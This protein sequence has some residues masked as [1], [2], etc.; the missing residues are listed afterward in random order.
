MGKRPARKILDG[1]LSRQ[2]PQ[3]K[4]RGRKFSFSAL[5]FLLPL[6]LVFTFAAVVIYFR[7]PTFT[8]SSSR[9]ESSATVPK[10]KNPW[11]V[12]VR[13]TDDRPLSDEQMAE[14]AAIV[15]DTV[16]QGKKS[17][18][19]DASRL[20]VQK[21]A[22]GVAAVTRTGKFGLVVSVSQRVPLLGVYADKPRFLTEDG[23][24]YGDYTAESDA[25]SMV[26][27]IVNGIFDNRAESF[28]VGSNGTLAIGPDESSLLKETA[29]LYKAI[30]SSN[31]KIKSID[32]R[33]FRGFFI[34]LQN[35]ET[36]VALGRSPF[37]G[38]LARLHEIL[39]RLEKT[40]STAARIEL[41]YQGKAFIK[42]KK[43]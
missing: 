31:H 8:Q 15:R 17:E 1:V 14:V 4:R 42:E 26:G 28:V 27:P 38:K 22:L 2:K 3:K 13:T 6:L 19:R 34:V 25:G 32:F 35:S 30:R 41:D 7:S 36:E 16:V 29:E 5:K 33:R 43:L 9:A 10:S 11:K 18:L 12:V 21:L 40:A 24:V 23:I 20:I 39:T 37:S